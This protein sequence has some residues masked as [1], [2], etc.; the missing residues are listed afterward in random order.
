MH[1]RVTLNRLPDEKFPPP[2]KLAPRY[3]GFGATPW[4][5]LN[6]ARLRTGHF[7][8]EALAAFE[9]VRSVDYAASTG[10]I[11]EAVSSSASKITQVQL[12]KELADG[13]RA[14]Y[15]RAAE[16]AREGK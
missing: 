9:D 4:R 15:R 8:P 2:P 10:R 6:D 13:F 7:P 14:T 3:C 11:R 16:L 5:A 12:A 1:F